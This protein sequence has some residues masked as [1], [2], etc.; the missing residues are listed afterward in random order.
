MRN[1]R[2]RWRRVV[3]TSVAVGIWAGTLAAGTDAGRKKTQSPPANPSV[4]IACDTRFDPAW[5]YV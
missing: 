3:E 4:G 1:Q 2:K 5:L